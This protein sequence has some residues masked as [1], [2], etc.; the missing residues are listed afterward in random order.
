MKTTLALT[1][2]SLITLSQSVSAASEY[3]CQDQEIG[4][5]EKLSVSVQTKILSKTAKSLTM[6]FENG[7]LHL[8]AAAFEMSDGL[9]FSELTNEDMD[10]FNE[11]TV[12]DAEK[13]SYLKNSQ[14]VGVRKFRHNYY[15]G[16]GFFRSEK[17][18]YLMVTKEYACS[19]TT[20][21]YLKL[22]HCTR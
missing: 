9:P 17:S 16:E 8:K 21:T 19:G 6:N 4:G 11:Q 10:K 18:A 1:L 2:L 20:C 15:L 14:E 13:V 3:K 7:S 5:H 22:F 12:V